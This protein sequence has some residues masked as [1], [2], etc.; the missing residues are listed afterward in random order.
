LTYISSLKLVCPKGQ[1]QMAP[2]GVPASFD[3]VHFTRAG[4]DYYVSRLFERIAAVL[5]AKR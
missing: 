1:C 2:H 4:A 5:A 3:I